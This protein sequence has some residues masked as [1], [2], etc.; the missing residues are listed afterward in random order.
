[1]LTSRILFFVA[2]AVFGFVFPAAVIFWSN[3][4]GQTLFTLLAISSVAGVCAYLLNNLALYEENQLLMQKI[5]RRA[6]QN[7]L[8]KILKTPRT[9]AEVEEIIHSGLYPQ[10][11]RPLLPSQAEILRRR[12]VAQLERL[13]NQSRKSRR[14]AVPVVELPLAK[15]PISD[16]RG[17]P[18]VNARKE[19]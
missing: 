13:T 17:L 11:E 9:K 2:L 8:F 1:M 14:Y 5:E 4:S 3:Y 6:V 16:A 15:L 7:G 19:G 18:F 12:D 10:D